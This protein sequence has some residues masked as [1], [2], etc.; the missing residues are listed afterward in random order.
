MERNESRE[1]DGE[2]EKRKE[3]CE[4]KQWQYAFED[5]DALKDKSEYVAVHGREGVCVRFFACTCISSTSDMSTRL[6]L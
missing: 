4:P 3:R 1:Y 2:S 6:S 5:E